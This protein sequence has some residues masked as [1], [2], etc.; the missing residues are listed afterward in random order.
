MKYISDLLLTNHG[1]RKE[2]YTFALC[3]VMVL[4]LSSCSINISQP[5][6]PQLSEVTPSAAIG[7]ELDSATPAAETTTIPITWAGLNLTGKLA[8][9]SS[10]QDDD[11]IAKIQVLNLATGE[12][13]T[14][15][16]SPNKGWIYYLTI[17]PDAKDLVMSYIPASQNNSTFPRILYIMPLDGSSPPRPLFSPPSPDDRYIQAEWSP[18]G[19]Y[20]YYV[21]YNSIDKP[22]AWL[23]PPYHL[24]RMAFPDGQPEKIAELAFW[25]RVSSDSTKLVYISIDPESGRNDLYVANADGSNSQLVALSGSG[26]PEILDA[27]I[28]SSDGQ[29]ILFSAP[30]PNQSSDRNWFEK[31]VGI[32]VARAHDVPS[33]WW[34]VPITGGVPT[35]LTNI[36]TINLFASISPDGRHIASVSGDGLFVMDVGGSSLTQLISDPGIHGTV[37]WIP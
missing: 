12:T 4:G 30:L 16:T 25:P 17:S 22:D 18:D 29:T 26:I 34:S 24:F 31:L 13:K 9:I 2:I 5:P 32:R 19:K 7:D 35:Q 21:Q 3:C 36:Q 8:Y 6:P 14:I 1:S 28:F 23:N 10:K 33:D 11:L 37:S 27:P 20:I 15:F